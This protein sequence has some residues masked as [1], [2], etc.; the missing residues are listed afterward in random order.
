MIQKCTN[1]WWNPLNTIKKKEAIKIEKIEKKR[2][3][4]GV[5]NPSCNFYWAE[6]EGS[7]LKWRFSCKCGEVCSYYE[8]YIF[9]PTGRMYECTNCKIWSHVKCNLG[10]ISDLE[11]EKLEVVFFLKNMHH[12]NSLFTSQI[13]SNI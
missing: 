6:G 4:K 8:K 2:K 7:K 13:I 1:L 11:L 12:F 3:L 9:H 5:D 10:D